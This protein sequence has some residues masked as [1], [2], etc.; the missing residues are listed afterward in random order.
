M[1]IDDL[2]FEFIKK[3]M[4]EKGETV[5][6]LSRAMNTSPYYIGTLIRRYKNPSHNRAKGISLRKAMDFLN[7]FGCTLSDFDAYSKKKKR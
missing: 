2:F 6:S 1:S 3:K 4:K 5:T 7:Y